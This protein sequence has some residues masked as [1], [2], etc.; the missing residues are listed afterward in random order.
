MMPSGEDSLRLQLL[1][2][3]Q[4]LLDLGLNRGTSGNAAVRCGDGMLITPSAMAV[5]DMT[6]ADMVRMDLKGNALCGGKPTSEWRFHRD[7]LANRPDVSAVIHTHSAFATT[8]ACLR[9]DVPAVHYMIAAAGGSMI[10]CTPYALFGEQTLS[11]YALSALEGRKACLLANHG[12]I[13]LGSDL[14]DALMVAIEV[15]FLCEVYWRALQAGEPHILTTQQ[16][17]DVQEK[18]VDYKKR[19]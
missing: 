15:E 9:E 12:M 13:A 3:S 5:A 14:A 6:P 19:T 7:I 4:R 11:D 16:M 1:D 2:V 17:H 8:L 18:F 10:R